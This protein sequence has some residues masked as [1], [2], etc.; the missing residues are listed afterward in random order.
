MTETSRDPFRIIPAQVRNDHFLSYLTLVELQES[1][2]PVSKDWK[3]ACDEYKT[4]WVQN[5]LT[6]NNQ[7]ALMGLKGSTQLNGK[8]VRIL[9]PPN[10]RGRIP[11]EMGKNHLTGIVKKVGVLI[12]NLNP[13]CT[14]NDSDTASVHHHNIP[15]LT[16]YSSDSRVRRSHGMML[17]QLLMLAR[18][19]VNVLGGRTVATSIPEF[20]TL[21]RSHP[22]LCELNK[23]IFMW[24][25]TNPKIAGHRNTQGTILDVLVQRL[26]AEESQDAYEEVLQEA[27]LWRADGPNG[28]YLARNYCR[29]LRTWETDRVVGAF[30]VY[31]VYPTGTIMV[32]VQ[33]HVDDLDTI[34]Q[35]LGT[36]YLV[37]GHSSVIGN[38]F[39]RLPMF[40]KTTLYPI[41]DLWTYD[42]IVQ[43][44]NRWAGMRFPNFT[45]ALDQHVSKALDE[46]T[47][48]WRGPSAH[49]WETLPPPPFPTLMSNEADDEIVL[50]WSSYSEQ[51]SSRTYDNQSTNRHV[52]GK[53]REVVQITEVH[54]E[55]A[56]KIAQSIARYPMRCSND[57]SHPHFTSV[58]FRRFGYSVKENPNMLCTILLHRLSQAIPVGMFPFEWSPSGNDDKIPTYTLLEIMDEFLQVLTEQKETPNV[59][60][61]DEL[62]VVGPLKTLLEEA[63]ETRKVSSP[64]VMWYPP[65][66]A[67]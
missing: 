31:K 23:D 7:V 10:A 48:S 37:K 5:Y 59:V 39:P 24:W 50:D 11:V 30:M 65:P 2:R 6:I 54:K 67:H 1:A 16:E 64:E 47:V 60:M 4:W 12:Q 9:G 43:A 56:D 41:Y 52:V 3:G 25:T 21:P 57:P 34:E 33:E 22:G 38:L 26:F 15:D 51:G 17:D 66:A 55:R 40:C 28:E 45:Q 58:T 53:S 19:Q 27:P 44:A 49:L 14:S 20:F 32:K 29:F 62:A 8:I 61:V 13:F 36:V 63:C 35:A 46:G 18:W 42:G